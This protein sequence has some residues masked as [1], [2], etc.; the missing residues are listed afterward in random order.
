MAASM[1]VYMRMTTA[2]APAQPQQPGMPNMKVIQNIM[3]ITMLFF[4]NKFASG[5][6]LYYLIA[7]LTSIG[8]MLVIKRF[9]IDEEKIKEKIAHNISNPKKKSSF[10]QKLEEMQKEQQKKTKEIKAKR[11]SRK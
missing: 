10:Q 4:F 8:Q 11:N 5:L 6:A 7:N 1:F 2:G 3:P 9:F